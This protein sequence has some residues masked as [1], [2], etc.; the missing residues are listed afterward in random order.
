[1]SLCG[2]VAASLLL[3]ACAT[4]TRGTKETFNIVTTPS[5][6]EVTLSNGETCVSPCKLKLKRKD[7]FSVTAKKAGYKPATAEV[8]SVVK[9][10]G[11]AG[12]AGNILVGGI[13][14]GI[15]DGSSGAMK[16]LTPNPLELTLEPELAPVVAE[17]PAA[18]AAEAA[19]VA[20]AA[21]APA[22]EAA[23]PAVEAAPA[24]N[25]TGGQ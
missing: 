2:L 14:G 15:V 25:P 23:A 6:A 3:P 8:R 17:A 11:V 19:P 20:A 4:V 24:A 1:M 12:A 9:G 7:E 5:E 13:I 21:E 18:P 16:D 22:A 10:G